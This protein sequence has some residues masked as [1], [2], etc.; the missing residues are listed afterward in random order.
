LLLQNGWTDDLFPAPE[1]LRA[2]NAMMGAKG[3]NVA[4][5]LGDL[6]HPRGSNKSNVQ[7]YFNAQGAR[8]FDAYLKGEEGK[9]PRNGS[10]TAFSQTCP[11]AAPGAG[12]YRASAWAELHPGA[13]RFGGT[14]G[15]RVTSTGGNPATGTAFDQITTAD[16]CRTVAQER[17]AGTAVYQR[18]VSSAYTMLGLPTVRARIR[19]KGAGGE[20]VARLW[21]VAGGRQ[22]LISRGVDRLADDE[23]GTITFQLFGNGWLF[24]PGHVA[25]LELVGSDP[26]YL[27]PSNEKFS[28]KV[29]KLTIELPTRDRPKA[30]RGID[31]PTLGG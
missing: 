22:R 14:A 17:A 28:V 19:T 20:L 13:F 15:Q 3:G 23:R 10:V 4:L 25:K 26:N 6:G 2:Y 11:N 27:R 12:P 31:V 21:D 30:S 5:Q 16:A 29:S 9:A 7:A 18:S 1:G 24:K 8:F